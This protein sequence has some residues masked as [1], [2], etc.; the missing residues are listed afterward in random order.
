MMQDDSAMTHGNIADSA[1][2]P[3][4]ATAPP[5]SAIPL[6]M[7]PTLHAARD[8]RRPAL[9]FEGR[10]ITRGEFEANA[11]RR[12]RAL[13]AMGVGADDFVT[14]ALPNSIEFY[15]TVFAIWKLG[16]T[17]NPVSARLPLP[18]FAAIVDLIDP[19]LVIGTV[20]GQM[21][22]RKILP[23]GTPVD[24]SLSPE[25][26][27]A[28]VTRYWKAMPS[29]GSTGRPKIIVDHQPGLW[30][31]AAP[32][33]RQKIDDTLL[34]VGP[35]YHNAGFT[36]MTIGLFTGGHVV[37]S[38]KFDALRTLE[39]I[40][41]HK[42]GW[43]NFV[44]TM[45]HR[46]WRLPEEQRN[47]F[48]LSSLHTVFHMASACP[49]WLKEKWIEWLG[50]DRLW[51][52]YGGTERTGQTLISGSEWLTHKG[53]VGK[54]QPGAMLRILNEAG[55]DCASGE[56]GE[57]FFLPDGGL[58]ST[59]HYIGAEAKANGDWQ[60][61]GDLGY[62]D[63]DGYLYIVDRRTDMIVC[64]GSNIYPAEV[65]AALDAHPSVGSSIVIG[66]PDDDLGH[67]VHALVE[68]AHEDRNTISADDLREFLGE[69]LA[70]NKIPRSFEFVDIP[71]RDDA[72]KARRSALRDERIKTGA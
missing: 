19:R 67:R 11:N 3:D 31:P 25:P 29:G 63:D 46:I 72:G 39:L 52:L 41:R 68:L 7:L 50:P 65:E 61:L 17:P 47:A 27:E 8:A 13:A 23:A 4:I 59:Y 5:D 49:V 60:S 69:R 53:S 40:E 20:P 18:E 54:V 56:I 44:P 21:P 28:R 37:E 26:L 35:L 70:F 48:D 45:M 2:R 9:S 14:L 24:E 30:D 32:P 34:N 64:G 36:C 33:A 55:G 22:G 15:E 16:A 57:I 58:N 12:A 42:V 66:L 6:G 62:L 43:V 1:G 10:S 71:L 38:G 51:E